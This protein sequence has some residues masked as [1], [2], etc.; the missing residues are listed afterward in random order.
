M[1]KPKPLHVNKNNIG[2]GRV[3]TLYNANAIILHWKWL[4]ARKETKKENEEK[5]VY[6]YIN[7]AHNGIKLMRKMRLSL[8]RKG[9]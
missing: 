3:D 2:F 7:K 6:V 4:W 9:E 8:Y 1:I 5:M